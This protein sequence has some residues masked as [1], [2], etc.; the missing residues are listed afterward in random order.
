MLAVLALLL[1][2]LM[3]VRAAAFSDVHAGDWFAKDVDAMTGD[4]L[5]RGYP[6][7]TFRP[8]DT[9][10]AA[11]FVSV[12][13]RCGGIPDS[14][15]Y[16]AHWAAGTMQAALD[17]GWYDWDEIPPSGEKYDKPIVRPAC[18]EHSDAGASAGQKRRLRNRNR[19]NRGFFSGGRA[20]F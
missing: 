14:V 17:A 2:C 12:V 18:G 13:A 7:G 6:D 4:G 9:I 20:V 16:D 8:N 15:T 19:E 5:L 11:E 10:T 1:V 3:P